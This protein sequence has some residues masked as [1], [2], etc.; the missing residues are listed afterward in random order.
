[1]SYLSEWELEGIVAAAKERSSGLPQR[2]R[3]VSTGYEPGESSETLYE[4]GTGNSFR[5]VSTKVSN[6]LVTK[7]ET[8]IVGS[9]RYDRRKDGTWERF[10]PNKQER[11]EG[12]SF[13][14][15]S[16]VASEGVPEITKT[17][18]I[19]GVEKVGEQNAT[20]YRAT[21]RLVFRLNGNVRT[22]VEINE[23]WLGE[24][25]LL[26]RVSSENYVENGGDRNKNVTDY[27]YPKQLVIT[28]P[29]IGKRRTR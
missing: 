24:N 12:S 15:G 4:F 20:R 5:A 9:A 14:I 1:M 16:G 11:S 23:Y 29:R 3:S 26:L 25:G 10:D 17:V 19:L 21:K 28:A 13:G 7:T 18:A 6:G 8:I 27:E 22:K 2:H